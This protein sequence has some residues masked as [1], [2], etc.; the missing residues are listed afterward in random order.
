MLSGCSSSTGSKSS[1]GSVTLSYGVWD[2]T[3]VPAMKEIVAQFHQAHPNINVRIEVTPWDSYWT[4]LKTAATGGSAP[5]VFWMTIDSFKLYAN[6]GVL[7]PLDELIKRDH[8]DM[9][10][11][12][13]SAV[14]GFN[15]K[16]Q[17]FGI[18]KDIDS[19]GLFYNKKLFTDAGVE[20]PNS[21]WTWSDLTNAAK[22]LT[23][24][25]KGVYGI[26]A[27][28]ADESGY[29]VT[30]PQ[31]GGYVISPDGK[32]SGFDDP[33]TIKGIQ[34]WTDLINKYHVSPTLQ[35]MTDTDPLAMFTSGKVAMYYGGSWDPVAI[36][37]VPYAKANVD[38]APLPMGVNR[39]FFASSLGNV[40]FGKTSHP[41]EAWEFVK[42]LGSKGA[43]DIQAKTGTVIPAYKGQETAYARSMPQLHLQV[44]ID[45][46]PYAKTF[47]SSVDS[48][49]WRDFAIKEFASAWTGQ[50]P[51]AQVAKRV[52]EQMNAALAKEP[53]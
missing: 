41:K 7:M 15:W 29:Y 46:L 17:N 34:F 50:E 24:K 22:K 48:A 23:N 25:D 13:K 10:S 42:F 4:K 12:A 47:P 53:K 45:Q 16:G 14:D 31:A 21:S 3:Q 18:P 11:Y 36:A 6:G 52:A 20:F 8:V 5:D 9:N 38:V 35:Q 39:T 44:F 49:V 19:H 40:I 32:K 33:A 37:A 1:E 28:L 30:I 26:A 51:V 2:E 43:A 27:P